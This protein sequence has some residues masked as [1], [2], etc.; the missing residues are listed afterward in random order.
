VTRLMRW[1]TMLGGAGGSTPYTP[2]SL[3]P[4]LW[5][6]A[7]AGY[8]TDAGTALATD[9]Q[10]VQQWSDQSG[11]GRHPSQA[12]AGKR[13]LWIANGQNG[14]PVLRFDGVDDYLKAAGFT[15]TQPET[16]FIVYKSITLGGSGTHD[17]IFDGNA[18][19]GGA[20]L[21]DVR[22]V[23]QINAGT[24]VPVATAAADGIFAVLVVQFSG[25]SS[26]WRLD[27]TQVATGDAGANDMNGFT[28]AALGN[29]SRTTNIDVGEVIVYPTALA[30]ADLQAVEA[31]L[32]ARWATP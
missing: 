25:A 23:T 17:T 7:D 5:A 19:I 21:S 10:S 8:Y 24:S 1:L 31:Y 32:K 26:F 9:G 16:V 27:G 13:P 14:L 4:A 20:F 15:L 29:N 28:L 6:K 22:P 18:T 11:N 3:S 30:L 12:T 2:L